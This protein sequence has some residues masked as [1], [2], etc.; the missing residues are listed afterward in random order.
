MRLKDELV[1]WKTLLALW[2]ETIR[3]N[4]GGVRPQSSF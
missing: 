1:C 4:F 3:V 2:V